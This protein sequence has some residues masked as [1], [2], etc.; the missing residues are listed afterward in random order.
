MK[1]FK[2]L[3]IVL[4][5]TLFLP[6]K[7][8]SQKRIKPPK[9]VSKIASADQFVNNAFELY[10]KVFVYDSLAKA[11]VDI[12]AELEDELLESAK[13]NIDSLWQVFPTIIDDMSSGDE[14]IGRKAKATLNLNKAKK[15]IKYCVKAVKVY[16]KGE[17]D[18]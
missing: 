2:T 12:P 8:Y 6:L 11:G 14:P 5:L 13:D 17:D 1:Y 4:V 3:I 16:F 10:H 9:R 7:S 18:E 15:A